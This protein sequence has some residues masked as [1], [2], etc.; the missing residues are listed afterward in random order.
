MEYGKIK[1][2]SKP[3]SRYIVGT[4][5]F[6]E[7]DY[8]PEY[9]QTLDNAYEAGIN[10]IDTAWSYGHPNEGCSEWV[11]GKW[12]RENNLRDKIIL[13]TKCCHPN[14]WRTKVHS[15][16]ILSEFHDSLARMQVD[17]VDVLY[18]HRDDP[19]TS[20][21]EIID[22]LDTLR[23]QGL[24]SVYGVANWGFER[25]KEANDYAASVGKQGF[26]F[27]E[28]HYSVAEMIDEPFMLGSGSISGPKYAEARKYYAEQQIPVASY[29]C[30]SGGFVTGRI[31]REG[32]KANPDSVNPSVRKG[33]CYDVNFDRLDRVIALAN[34]KGVTPAQIGMAYTMGS[35]MDVYPIVGALNK[36]E[37][38]SSLAALDIKLTKAECDWLDLTSN[39]R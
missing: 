2:I 16:D 27:I 31:T 5:Q 14:D 1:G 13:T 37:L 22:T 38:D 26:S 18:L 7:Y 39:E 20:V 25:I 23:T 11:V 15:Y 3:A 8:K 12:I 36:A 29:S 34:E 33:Y 9:V 35:D 24:V 28:E 17:Y 10:V 32:F 30:L 19:N 6:G 21:Q 4:M